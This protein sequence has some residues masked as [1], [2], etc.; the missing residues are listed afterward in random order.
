MDKVSAVQ[1]HVW[2]YD[3]MQTVPLVHNQRLVPYHP[4]ELEP[5]S[6]ATTRGH[7]YRT[8]IQSSPNGRRVPPGM[9]AIAAMSVAGVPRNWQP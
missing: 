9:A 4:S 5:P 7:H 3:L 1:L 8:E 2:I 6:T